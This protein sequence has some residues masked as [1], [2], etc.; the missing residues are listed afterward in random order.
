VNLVRFIVRNSIEEE[1]AR[2]RNYREGVITEL[3]EAPG[4]QV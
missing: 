4:A 2:A 3:D 1:M